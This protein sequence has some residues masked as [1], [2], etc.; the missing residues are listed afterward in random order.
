MSCRGST[1]QVND[2]YRAVIECNGQ[3]AWV[4][5]MD[6]DMPDDHDEYGVAE[7]YNLQKVI[8]GTISK[9]EGNGDE[10]WLLP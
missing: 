7:T 1:I 4:T 2:R 3:T 10:D 8:Q 5:L 9:Y 6:D